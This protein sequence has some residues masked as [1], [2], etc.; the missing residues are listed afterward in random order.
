MSSFGLIEKNLE[1]SHIYQAVHLIFYLQ[2]CGMPVKALS[3]LCN[4]LTNKIKKLSLFRIREFDSEDYILEE[5]HVIALANRCPL[6]EEL[7]LGGQEN[8]ISE[9]AL[10]TII[11]KLQNL[12]KLKL[13]DTGRI[14]FPK[15][16]ELGSMPNL[17]YLRVHVD[18]SRMGRK[19]FL[20]KLWPKSKSELGY[21]KYDKWEKKTPLIKALAKN[22]PNLKI[23]EGEFE[24]AHPDSQILFEGDEESLWEIPCNPTRDFYEPM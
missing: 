14:P 2:D 6:L 5:K 12:V 3:F 10:T 8:F 9:D 1:L 18:D 24:I 11:E 19:E 7:D 13:P 21:D 16:L 4:N 22:L 23:N 15:L 20:R 17:K